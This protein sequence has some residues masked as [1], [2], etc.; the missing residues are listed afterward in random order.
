M[1]KLIVSEFITL[2]GVIQAPGG[3]EEDTEG[4]FVHGGWTMPFWHDGVAIHIDILPGQCFDLA[5]FL[6]DIAANE[7]GV[8]PQIG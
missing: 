2:D 3:A 1:R 6:G 8:A 5:D 7:G 4:G